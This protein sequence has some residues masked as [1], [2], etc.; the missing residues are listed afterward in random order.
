MAKTNKHPDPYYDDDPHFDDSAEH[1]NRLAEKMV[2]KT[3][4]DDIEPPELNPDGSM[5]NPD[6]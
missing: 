3:V 2:G 6:E 5:K 4:G 1:L